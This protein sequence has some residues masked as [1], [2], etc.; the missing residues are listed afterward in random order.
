MI[1]G[2]Y[3][4]YRMMSLKCKSGMNKDKVLEIYVILPRSSASVQTKLVK[5]EAII[6]VN[7]QGRISIFQ[8]L[9][10]CWNHLWCS[11]YSV[12]SSL[13][14]SEELLFPVSLVPDRGICSEGFYGS[15]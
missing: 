15:C 4:W 5:E 12:P 8:T 6:M 2:G 14:C 10:C 3:S 1:G 9:P 7:C 11:N 13:S